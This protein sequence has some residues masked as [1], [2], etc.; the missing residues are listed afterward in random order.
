MSGL[1]SGPSFLRSRM[2]ALISQL[3][4]TCGGTRRDRGS[5]WQRMLGLS[6]GVYI[7]PN[8]TSEAHSLTPTPGQDHSRAILSKA[9]R[10]MDISERKS[11]GRFGCFQTS[12]LALLLPGCNLNTACWFSELVVRNSQ[13]RNAFASSKGALR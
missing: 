4:D 6:P 5:L 13:I 7:L 9:G 8:R 1:L 11:D 3:D 12:V 10:E 2:Q